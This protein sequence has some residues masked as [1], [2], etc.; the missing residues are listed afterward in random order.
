VCYNLVAVQN[1]AWRKYVTRACLASD[2]AMAMYSPI[3][4]IAAATASIMIVAG[5]APWHAC[6]SCVGHECATFGMPTCK[7]QQPRRFAKY[8]WVVV[9]AL[10]V[11]VAGEDTG[12]P[13][14]SHSTH[15]DRAR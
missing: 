7:G 3:D 13:C 1:P 8:C 10:I 14:C 5:E 6:C 12:V 9:A 11:I 15:H 4:K 2:P